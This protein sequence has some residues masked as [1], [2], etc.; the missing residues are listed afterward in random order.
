MTE[1]GT[2]DYYEI[3]FPKLG[4]DINVKSEAFSIGNFNIQ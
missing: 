1:V 2:L 4:I 3:V